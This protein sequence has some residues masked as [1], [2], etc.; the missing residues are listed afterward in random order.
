MIIEQQEKR[1]RPFYLV[2]WAFLTIVRR[3]FQPVMISTLTR[4]TI[5]KG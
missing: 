5:S 1:A 3:P 4:A 2:G